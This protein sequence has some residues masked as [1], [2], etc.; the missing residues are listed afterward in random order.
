[1]NKKKRR[2][3]N[4]VNAHVLYA[5][6]SRQK[7]YVLTIKEQELRELSPAEFLNTSIIIERQKSFRA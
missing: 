3:K 2:K 4:Y 6:K 1:M 7:R 5:K